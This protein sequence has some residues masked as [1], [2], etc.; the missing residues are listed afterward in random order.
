[1][2]QQYLTIRKIFAFVFPHTRLNRSLRILV[3]IN[4]V[5]VFIVG[6]FAPFYAV[7]VQKIGGNI[8]FAGLSWAIFLIVGG[9]LIFLF[10]NW[11]LKIKEQE[12]LIALGYILTGGV[13]LSYAFM[14][15]IAQLIVTQI[16]WGVA[17]ALRSPAFDSVYSNHTTQENSLVEWGQWEGI[18]AIVTGIAALVGGL[19]I[20]AFGY[21]VIF[22]IMAA[23]SFFLGIYIIRLPRDV[24]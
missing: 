12:L 17:A 5:F 23:T 6:L 9:I 13:F 24:L 14:A 19:F 15:S 7:F 20:Q 1:M 4:A 18:A 21:A 2:E 16:L 11:G 3:A 10:S 22:L 8:A